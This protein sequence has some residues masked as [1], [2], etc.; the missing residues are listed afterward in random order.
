MKSSCTALSVIALLG[1]AASAQANLLSNPS[2]EGNLSPWISF[3]NAFHEVT[4]APAISPR[5]GD[6]ILKMFGN[7]SGGFN[8][9][10]AF[11]EFTA[12]PGQ[13]WTMDCYS[14]NFSG[15]AMSGDNT[16]V[17]K[18]AFFNN[19]NTEIGFAESIVLSASSPTDTWIDNAPVVGIAP[20]DT[21]KVQAF[22]LFL[23]PAF[24]GGA[25]QFDDVSLIPAPGAAALLAGGML[26]AGRRRR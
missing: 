21:V 13:A 15:D 3:G 2:F 17:M 1:C 20:A 10:G 22:L 11:Q 25:G 26:L 5:T 23:Q 9:T 18:L 19:L 12:A 6:G 8:V 14:R 16:V 4:N 7:F 24:A